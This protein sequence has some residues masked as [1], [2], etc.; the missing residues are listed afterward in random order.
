MENPSAAE[1]K[2]VV[3]EAQTEAQ[4]VTVADREFDQA[5]EAL[6]K[7]RPQADELINEIMAE[8]RFRL[9]KRDAASQRRIM[10]TYGA[11][12]RYLKGEPVEEEVVE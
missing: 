1:L 6:G 5:Q 3:D 8:L 12:Y 4:D 9:R 11:T 7:L 10:R 2:A